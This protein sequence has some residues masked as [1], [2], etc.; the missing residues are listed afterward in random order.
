MA[1]IG[2]PPA[3]QNITSAGITDGTIVNVDIAS[4]AAIAASKIAGLST[5]ATT[6]AYADVT[7][8]PTL[9]TA[10]GSA[11]GDFATAAQGTKADAAL[12]KAGGTL[13]G[14]IDG[15]GNKVLFANVYSALSDL[16]SA[17]TYHGMFAHVHATGKGYFA[18]AGSWVEI[19][20]QTDLASTTTTANAALPKAG[21]AVT[22][23]ITT[24]STFDGVDIA[25]RDAVLT[26]TTT[27]ANAA[28][29]KA[30]GA[31]TGNVTFGDNN[32]AIFGAGS[33]LNIWH[34]GN[35]SN[36]RDSGTGDLRL[37]GV[38]VSIQNNTGGENMATF[39]VDGAVQL[40][41]DNVAKLSTT[42]LGVSVTGEL[43][44]S[45][46]NETYAAVTSSSNATT[47][48]CHNGNTFSH[49]L[50]E[51]TTFTFSNPPAS[52]TGYTMSIEIIQDG[53]A[54]GFTVTWPASVDW[55]AATAPT[56]TATASAKDVFVFTTRDGG[57]T[58]Y[59]FTAGQAL[60]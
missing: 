37:Q 48:N 59:G 31:V 6:G 46:Y 26:T 12:P 4:D 51:N 38:N 24:N 3:P 8:T 2:N 30:G 33:D 58:W 17:T 28:L 34:D 21:G 15:N 41:Y 27:T 25:T 9:G 32:K 10:A 22:G 13:S 54:S 36:V 39:G 20:N 1:Y 42:A 47:A 16:P 44:A 7:G 35:H 60:A 45:S 56:L 57:T 43:I 55:P 40:Y 14:D 19:A 50:T 49:T 18:H 52:G 23:A 11:T 5:V 29:P 53:S